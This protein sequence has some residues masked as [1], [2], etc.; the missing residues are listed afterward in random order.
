LIVKRKKREERREQR[1]E[2][3]VQKYCT[4]EGVP[5]PDMIDI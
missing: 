3:S 4:V 5:G 2:R 1:E